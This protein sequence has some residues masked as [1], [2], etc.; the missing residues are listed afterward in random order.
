M[1]KMLMT[2]ML[3]PMMALAKTW[4]VDGSTGSDS[5]SGRSSLAAKK[6]IQAAIDAASNDDLILVKPGTYGAVT[7]VDKRVRILSLK[8]RNIRLLMGKEL[9]RALSC[10]ILRVRILQGLH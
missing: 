4:I 3:L 10:S 9:Q 2:I 1:K 7:A 6:T 5:N 8:A